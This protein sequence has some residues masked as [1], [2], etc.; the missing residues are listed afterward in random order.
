MVGQTSKV[1]LVLIITVNG[2]VVSHCP[3]TGDI[4][5]VHSQGDKNVVLL[6]RANDSLNSRSSYAVIY[7][8]RYTPSDDWSPVKLS[9]AVLKV[10]IAGGALRVVI[11]TVMV[12]YVAVKKQVIRVLDLV[13]AKSKGSIDALIVFEKVISYTANCDVTS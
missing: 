7:S 13:S 11:W 2:V 9:P 3:S 4:I 10:D 8:E 12:T 6:A 1:V 5:V